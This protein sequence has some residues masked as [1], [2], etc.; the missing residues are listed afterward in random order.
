MSQ[1]SEISEEDYLHVKA[2]SYETIYQNLKSM[3]STTEFKEN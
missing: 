3:Y 1:F 2:V